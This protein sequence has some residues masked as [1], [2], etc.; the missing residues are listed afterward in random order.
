MDI[1]KAF[2]ACADAL[3]QLDSDDDER[4]RCV[5]S[6]AICL[7]IKLEQKKPPEPIPGPAQLGR[8]AC[9][10]CRK[11]GHNA[12]TCGEDRL[13]LRVGGKRPIALDGRAASYKLAAS[14]C[15]SG[16]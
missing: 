11:P 1:G 14:E 2:G 5:R 15:W 9:S 12:A 13:S 4:E 10:V 6:L 7:G 16:R 8:R 3:R